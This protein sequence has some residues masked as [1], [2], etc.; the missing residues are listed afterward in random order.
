MR[1]FARAAARSGE[2]ELIMGEEAY[3]E[4]TPSPTLEP[5]VEKLWS[6]RA[7]APSGAVQRIVPD[8]CCEL[9]LHLGAP[10]EEQAPDGSWGIQP[11]VLFAGQLTRPL[12]LRPTGPV[13]VLAAR[14][15]PD[16]PRPFLGRPLSQ[17]T[18]R[19]LDMA[20]RLPC[21]PS[22]LAGLSEG[23]D[24]LRHKEGW[25]VH[26]DVRAALGGAAPAV[27][28]RTL[29]RAFLDRVGVSL[30][31]IRSIRRFRQVFGR[32]EHPDVSARDWLS[33]GLEAGYFDQPQLARDFRRFLGCT[34]TE[35]AREQVE[36]ARTLATESYKTDPAERP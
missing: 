12:A 36:L 25:A 7:D 18:D 14:F 30:Q 9:I 22:D 10:Y 11:R 35:W 34:A 23:L 20:G 3:D 26:P 27:G 21:T 33:A 4:V 2:A 31:T 29:Q 32:A 24:R 1:A 8:G 19:T 15:T 6:Y 28:P 5:F 17:A 13:R 16:G